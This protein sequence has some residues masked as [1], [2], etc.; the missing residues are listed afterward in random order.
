MH[1]SDIELTKN[2]LLQPLSTKGLLGNMILRISNKSFEQDAIPHFISTVLLQEGDTLSK[3]GV[4]AKIVE[5]SGH[6]TGSIG[7]LFENQL[8]VGDALMNMFYPTASMLYHD[9]EQMLKSA[10]RISKMGELKIFFGHGNA[11]NN[12]KW[13]K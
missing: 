4:N 2:N 10:D 11:V 13:V 5:L 6:T 1:K 7:I 8:I 3:H 12:R 9:L